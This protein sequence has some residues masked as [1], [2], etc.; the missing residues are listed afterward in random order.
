MAARPGLFDS[1]RRLLGTTVELAQLRLEL[2]A[3]DLELEKLRLVGA[4]LRALVGLLLLG[5]G[6]MLAVGFVL[7]IVEPGRRMAALG[8]MAVG[9]VFVG[10]WLLRAARLHLQ[11]GGPMFSA[12]RAELDRDRDAFGRPD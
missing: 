4:A 5:I 10:A 9:F 8:L 1:L 7:L 12:T 3:S 6:L 11:D 2:L